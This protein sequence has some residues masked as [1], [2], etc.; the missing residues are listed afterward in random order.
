MVSG[1]YQDCHSPCRGG[2]RPAASKRAAPA[3]STEA[4]ESG[5]DEA[6]LAPAK[7]RRLTTSMVQSAANHRDGIGE[8]SAE[9]RALLRSG[10]SRDPEG[11]IE[12]QALLRS[13]AAR[14][15]AAARPHA[16]GPPAA[17]GF[18]KGIAGGE[19]GSE[20]GGGGDT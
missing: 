15:A 6:A 4:G 12:S 18:S 19:G 16:V 10:T 17:Q 3:S 7:T 8:P 9:R 11:K 1:G 13:A 5:G 2:L 20:V 14:R